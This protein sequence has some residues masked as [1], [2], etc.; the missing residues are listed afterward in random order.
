VNGFSKLT[1]FHNLDYLPA[2]VFPT[3]PRIV[4]LCG[5]GIMAD[6][7][8]IDLTSALTDL[9]FPAISWRDLKNTTSY[10]AI[11]NLQAPDQSST[12]FKGKCCVIV[13]TLVSYKILEAKIQN[14]EVLIPVL[15]AKFQE[16][17]S[18]T[19]SVRAC[20]IHFMSSP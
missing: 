11:S 12:T 3:E 6:C 14:P 7:Y 15:F 4:A 20:T 5:D 18:S 19:T 1:L 9:K 2:N 16:L 13:P 10:N 8:H 17:N